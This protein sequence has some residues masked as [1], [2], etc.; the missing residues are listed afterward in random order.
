MRD[1]QS[2]VKN[3][4]TGDSWVS[5]FWGQPGLQTELQPGLHKKNLVLK[6]KQTNKYQSQKRYV[7][8]AT[9]KLC[10]EHDLTLENMTE[11]QPNLLLATSRFSYPDDISLTP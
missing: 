9:F 3:I 10:L 1:K 4:G 5:E 7:S 8:Y 11:I 2:E 6:T